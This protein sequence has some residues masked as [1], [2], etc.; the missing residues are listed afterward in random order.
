MQV[1]DQYVA[2]ELG[3]YNSMTEW[4]PRQIFGTGSSGN[5]LIDT[6]G[7]LVVST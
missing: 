6:K 7:I 2:K 3:Y 4:N 5:I 1:I